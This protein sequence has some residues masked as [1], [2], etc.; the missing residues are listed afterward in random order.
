MALVS[1]ER[2]I[3]RVI[4]LRFFLRVFFRC[5][6]L[7]D[8]CKKGF[9]VVQLDFVLCDCLSMLVFKFS[10]TLLEQIV[11]RLEISVLFLKFI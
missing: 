9:E 2:P 7:I 5:N 6:F 10:V 3:D 1:G 8:S 11:L 4:A